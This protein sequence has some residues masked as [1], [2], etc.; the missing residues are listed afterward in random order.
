MSPRSPQ[1]PLTFHLAYRKNQ[2]NRTTRP[3]RKGAMVLWAALIGVLMAGGG[4]ALHAQTAEG[5]VITN[6]ATATYTDA[7]GNTYAAASGQVSVTVGF[8]GS[9]AVSSPGA[10]SP[11]SPSTGNAITWSITNNGNG[12]DQVQIGSSSSDT[13]VAG[14]ITYVYNSTP[15]A[16]L[17]LLNAAL[18]LPTDSV[19]AGGTITIDI[20]YDVQSGQ[21]G[22]PSNVEMTVSST[23]VGGDSNASTTVVT[24]AIA[25]SLT[26]TASNPTIDRLPSN[27]TVLYVESFDVTSGLTGSTTID[28]DATVSADAATVVITRIREGPSGA[29]VVG[30]TTS[31]TFGPG[32]TRSIEV[33][34]RVD[35]A[36]TDA[37][38]SSTVTLTATANAVAGPPTDADDHVVTIIAPSLSVVKTVHGSEADAQGNTTSTLTG[39][40]QPGATI[41]Y[42]V[43]VTNNGTAN[44]VMAGGSNGISDDLT[45]LPVAYVAASLNQTGSPI[46]WSTLSES[47]GVIDGTIAGGLPGGGSTAWFVFAVTIN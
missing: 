16:N 3:A 10:A 7:N 29:W 8:Q 33:E 37:G 28:L 35:G 19:P 47:A 11:S 20:V 39:D 1:D 4:N 25:G 26:T 18:A 31:L 44:A 5:T 38:S 45:G 12:S 46:A 24:P 6:T 43:Q 27:G 23:R 22:N 15:Y 41:W 2:M 13:N 9:L 30:N 34:Y 14:N 36:V 17:T 21:G 42:R 40:P 32:Q